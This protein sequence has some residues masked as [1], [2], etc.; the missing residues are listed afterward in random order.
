MKK[1]LAFFW[2]ILFL[3]IG[4]NFSSIAWA[5]VYIRGV[6]VDGQ[7]IS[8]DGSQAATVQPGKTFWIEVMIRQ[9]DAAFN[10]YGQL[11][12]WVENYSNVQSVDRGGFDTHTVYPAGSYKWLKD[13]TRQ[14]QMDSVSVEAQEDIWNIN[15]EQTLKLQIT[16]PSSGSVHFLARATF[17]DT[18]WNVLD[19]DPWSSTGYVDEQGHDVRHYTI[20]V[21]L[22][23]T[24]PPTISG[25]SASVDT[26]GRV[27]VQATVTDSGTGVVLQINLT[28]IFSLN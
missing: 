28:K 5:Y 17:C 7:S 14:E 18:N 21:V 12:L 4:L 19:S 8:T 2:T 20:N 6:K 25:V 27:T 24:T 22:V 16:A 23:D 1:A 9:E 15:E 26:S 3:F 10:G 13:S 11:V